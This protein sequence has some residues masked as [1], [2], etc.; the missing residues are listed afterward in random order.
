MIKT[1]IL[2]ATILLLAISLNAS[3]AINNTT[4]GGI[5]TAING[6]SPGDTVNL[7]PGNY[8]GGNNR[9]I[10]INKNVTIQGNGSAADVII[11]ALGSNRI[12]II[13]NNLNVTFINI[14]F[15]NGRSTDG[16]AIYNQYFATTMT[17]I[18][19]TF[20]NNNATRWGGAISNNGA[21]MIVN[22]STFINNKATNQGG[23]IYNTGGVNMSVSGSTFINNSAGYGV[24][25]SYGGTIRNDAANFS[26]SGSTFINSSA[27]YG[28]AIFTTDTG[29]NVSVRDSN[30]TNNT[31][32]LFGGAISTQ[33]T[34][35]SVSGSIF[36]NNKATNPILSLAN[37]SGGGAIDNSGANSS[38]IGSTF[39]NNSAVSSILSPGGA[40]GGAIRNTVGLSIIGSTFINN[41]AT[42]FGGAIFSRPSN[43]S[44]IDSTFI[45]S[46][47]GY[48][49]GIFA[50]GA[51]NSI[52]D[53]NFTGNSHAVGLN[54]TNFTLSGNRIIN[55]TVGIQFVLTNL[56]Y[57]ISGLNNT[58]IITDNLFAVAISGNN[59]NYTVIDSFGYK[60]NSGFIFT[61]GASGNRL[62]GNFTGYTRSDSSGVAVMFNA[63]S[64]N[65]L[66]YN[67]TI[68]GSDVGVVF[69]G[70]N[71]N[72]TGSNIVNNL[73]GGI[74]VYNVTGNRINYN[75]IY[76]N[77]GTGFDIVN[78]GT[79]TNA[80]LNWWGKNNISSIVSGVNTNNHYILNITNTSSLDNVNIGESI[81]FYLLVLNTTLT[82]TNVTNLPY[83]VI[84]GTFNGGAY[85]SSRDSNFTYVFN[86]LSGETQNI[87]ASLDDEYVFIN[88]DVIKYSTNS[89]IIFNPNPVP[90]GDNVTV[91]GQLANYTGISNVNVTVDGKT[92]TNVTVNNTGGWNIVYTTN[93]TGTLTVVVS[94][95]GNENYTAFT[96]TTTFTVA[97]NSTN[98][99]IIVNPNPVNIGVNTTISGILANYTG[100]TNVTVI[101]G[102]D[103]R[104]VAVNSTGGWSMNYTTTQTGT[105]T[106]I[107]IFNGNDNYTSFINST[108]FTVA[109]NS[110][111]STVVV[112]PN[113]VQIGNNVIV[114]G[115]LANYSGISSVTVIIGGDIR[116]VAVNSTGGW[117]MNYTTTQTGTLT[118]IVSFAG[119]DNYTSF[120]NS[121]TFTVNKNS[122]NSTIVVSPNPVQIGV[123]T[124]ISGVLANY[125]GITSVTV[126]VD[127]IQFNVA[128]NS[129]G[130]WSLN[131]TTIRTGNLTVVVSFAGNDNYTSFINSTTF[132][133]AK[134]STNSTIVVSPNPVQIGNNVTVSGV[135]ANYSGI[136]SVTVTV[137]GIQFNVA[138]NS[139]GGWSLN[140]TTVRTG[141]LT[142]VVSFA[143]NDNYT[144]FIN[145]TTFTVAKNS[146]NSTVLVSPNPVQIGNNV[147]VSGVLANYSGISSVTVTVD[148]IQFNVAVN[149]TGGWSLNYTTVRTGNL[150]VVVS[151]AGNDNYTSFINSTTFT[152]AK[153][154]TNSTVLVSPNPVQIGNNVTVS[155]V[156][157]NYSG[158]SSV[159]VTVDGI[160]F[161]V[162]VNSTGG[163]SVVYTTIRTGTLTVVVSFAGNDNYTAF[164]N[165]TTFTVAKNSTNSTI[166]VSPDPVSIG[167][168]VTVSGVLANYSGISSVNVIIDGDVRL[169]GVNSTGGWSLNYATIRTGN[170]NVVVSF[171]G[172][173]NYTNFINS[174]TFTVAKNSTNSTIAVSPDPV[175][176]GNNVTVSGVLANYSGIS[177]VNVIIDGDVR[178][179][180]VNST[181]GWSL[182]YATIRTGNLNVVVS[183]FGND[184]YTNFINSTTFTV[185]KNS[186]NSTIAVSPDPVSIGN[187]VTVSGVLANY[188]GISSVNVIIDGDVRLVGVN[189]TG[190]WSVVYTTIRTGNLNVVVSFFG[191]DNYTNFINSTT[192][193]VAKNSTNSTIFVSPN[194]VQIGNNVTVSGVLA[195][196]SGISS[197]N[198]IIDGM[199][200]I[201]AVNGSGGW[202]VVYTTVRTG[203][204][205]VVVSFA[206]NDNYTSFTN[207]TTFTV[208]K[209]ST[210]ST[211][212]VSPNPVQI[213][214]NVTVSGV[215]ANYSGISNVT[216]TV[217]G[218]QFIVAVNSTGGWSL[219]YA[220]IRTGSIS[221]VVGLFGNDNYT[222]FTN[223]T[224]FTVAKNST[225]STVVVSPNPVQ[226][227]NNVTVSG[228]L[229]NYSGISNV[230]VTVDGIQFI[231]A[232]N[233][234]G[235]WS[236]VYT[237]VRTGSISVVVGLFG[238]GNF[239]D[240]SNSTTFTVAKNSTNSTVVVSPNPVNI[241][242]NVTVSG[243]LAN[244]SGIN[245]VI[246]N[247]D[248]MQFIVAVNGSGGWS[249]VYTTVRT[250]SV[251]VVVGFAG[252]D[253]YTSFTNSTTF[254]VAKNS[255]NS[256][257]LVN[258]NPVQIGVNTT[259]SG[260]L[261]NYSGISNVTVNVDGMQFIVAVNSTGG[262]SV[263][264]TTVRTG[265]IS[266]VVGFAGNDNYTSFTN[267]T[268]FTVAKNSTNSTV[269]VNPNPVQIGVNTTISGVLA[270]YTGISSVIVNVDGMQFIVAVNGSGGW[271][272]VY[273][274][275][276]TGSVSVVVGFAGNDNYTSFINS[277]TFTVAKNSTNS[278]VLVNPN[279]VQIGVNTTISGVL[280][281]YTG[282]NQVNV[283]VD[284]TTFANVAVDGFGYWVLNYTTNRTGNLTVVVGFAG[285]D[286]YTSFINSTT[287]TVAKNSTNSTIVVD[288]VQIGENATISGQ[289]A[290][291]TGISSV[292]VT[293]DGIQF[294]VAVNGS[295][296][297]SLNYTTV[298]TGNLTVVVG[299]A[300]NDNYTSFI[301][302]TTFTVAKNSTNST[303]VVSP[304]P[305]SIGSN[306]TV[307]GVLANYT[308]IS[309]VNVI[310]DG[311]QFNVAVDGS[312]Y[313]VLNYT[314]NRTGNLTV[315]V[316][317]AGNDNYTS[318]TNSTNFTVN[319]VNKSST[320]STVVVSPNP[321]SIGNNVTVSG[322]LAN[323]TGI[324]SVNV[325]VD[326]KQFNVAVDGSGGWSMVYTANRTGNLT[327][328][329]GFAGNDNYTSFTNSTNFTVNMA[330]KSS[331]NST[332]VV[333]PN[334]VS[335][336]N[337]VTVSGQLANYT[338]ITSVNVTVDGT[339]FTVPVNGS[340]GWSMVYT[341]NRTGNLTVVVSFAGNDN[342]TSFTNTT[343]FNVGKLGVKL[344]VNVPGTVK[345][346][347]TM[348]I[349]GVL[350]DENGN[351]VANALINVTV[352][353]KVYSLTTD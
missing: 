325:I 40:G 131:Y 37:Y 192:F 339:L 64:T 12:F 92:F 103:I 270:N 265:S 239:S 245:S 226:I 346:G 47:A 297:W 83:F 39:I 215:L 199:Q 106:V 124:T 320:N 255:T 232:V 271:S 140:Y 280:A 318:F 312:G 58:N 60:D 351:P 286:N 24:G 96:N 91:S 252:N 209:N 21:N 303:V 46:S 171:F 274:T 10:T 264:Y 217:D 204:L 89:T 72:L 34:N 203:N 302:S 84:N 301:N 330:N 208:A 281:N 30:F 257:V 296:A 69:N 193:T 133:V 174:T 97:K 166:V 101:I 86:I 160:Q 290:N 94:F 308:G 28:G 13:S 227:G 335:I 126:T 7:D 152:V 344:T 105:L 36:I 14:T 52:L 189:S 194:P 285:N 142:V 195:N 178:L 191:N 273:T 173:D 161:N 73:N 5:N 309:F 329:V 4:T 183:F 197:V 26:V 214:N 68:N 180:G 332:V 349:D 137:D 307:S 125:T 342:Y 149:S 82:N 123:N 56:N 305:V 118:V 31:A 61:N 326:G 62:T 159:T 54:T 304:D 33:G 334:P 146:T 176:I 228:V 294:N 1:S 348:I 63:T 162:A 90:I 223:S 282:I 15:A 190:G 132:T 168:N 254:T 298:R 293:V 336:G 186:T 108:T 128:V 249:V 177:S 188:S 248:G 107:I 143:G 212:V 3:F 42:F 78:L 314:A 144:S 19:C 240:F 147:T 11:D 266:V 213:G 237:T 134:N 275:V 41:T 187:N 53:S 276:R 269:L 244:Y 98:S 324:A 284:G 247:V 263:V 139:T 206:G 50:M 185:A 32:N 321:V 231:V 283:I 243:V 258:P 261:A 267:S 316:G 77:N 156:L 322:V 211:I 87:D 253:N 44:V 291:S 236:V 219:N 347:K 260:V 299:F 222:S 9:G 328:V 157:A 277:T 23:A 196:Y 216:V 352:D 289:L 109:K 295:G 27:V 337:N 175:S 310:V 343:S 138:V 129:T 16:G 184:N 127:G 81:N 154:S 121:T 234:S 48:G 202:S 45:N 233:G 242:N 210:N 292:T 59:T 93:R 200:F 225:N 80:D 79:N 181:G 315:V 18:N 201:V 150:T 340:G 102:G 113:P 235:G 136:S 119:N 246:V 35:M 85:N 99:T 110:T 319:M 205:T 100:I 333:S 306:V 95:A 158:I 65:N 317:F 323:Y 207:S 179:V 148:G 130:G 70:T 164:T 345:V 135:L 2:I 220:T 17:F 341:A 221:V 55:N 29:P 259:I 112:S 155:G 163:W 198:V 224:T 250:G 238:H 313:W 165:S 20:T 167:N 151:F 104:S 262:W 311:K 218:I 278:T 76:N 256:T 22:G 111:N 71:N 229:A 25:A 169:V 43:F 141:N 6:A 75:R 251:S 350:V 268:T 116:S 117:S 114:S 288:N 120:I 279:P 145:S 287:F 338:G 57:N 122:T 230:T 170:L 331:T 49:G 182:N 74:I 241:G 88:F 153:N 353:G 327:V 115:V 8:T 172:N 300:G 66:V 272:V 51:N 67:S 38:I